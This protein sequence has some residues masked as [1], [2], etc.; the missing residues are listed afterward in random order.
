MTLGYGEIRQRRHAMEHQFLPIKKM[1]ES[2]RPYEKCSQFGV[3]SLS[4]AE[5]LAVIIK[6]GTRDMRCTEVAAQILALDC[7]QNGLGHLCQLTIH[8]LMKVK[9]IGQVKATQILC[10]AELSRRIAKATKGE[11]LQF[12]CSES[13][14]M[15]YMEDFRHYQQEH[16]L[17]IM[18]DTKGR[19]IKDIILTKGT[20]NST[21]IHPREIFLEA[22]RY[23]AVNII[24]LHNHPSGDPMPS[25]EDIHMT[26]KVA[27]VG[28]LLGIPLLDHIIIGDNAYESL[29]QYTK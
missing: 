2:E 19:L 24:L 3:R 28:Q 17:L 25:N 11:Q 5:L 1:P 8:Q 15:Y 10:V 29:G 12:D 16:L 9:G 7:G 21:I 14:A 6:T 4:D 27:R 13:V 18:L 26:K 20:I 23:E 22:L